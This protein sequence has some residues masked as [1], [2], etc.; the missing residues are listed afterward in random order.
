MSAD[1]QETPHP[2]PLCFK[3]SPRFL[4]EQTIKYDIEEPGEQM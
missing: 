4:L 2:I 3:K 1:A